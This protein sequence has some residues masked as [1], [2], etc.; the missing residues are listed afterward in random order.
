MRQFQIEDG[1]Q[2]SWLNPKIEEVTET[3]EIWQLNSVWDSGMDPETERTG[4]IQMN[5]R[6]VLSITTLWFYRMSIKGEAG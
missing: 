3:R 5:I 1:L 6:S 4:Q 2:D